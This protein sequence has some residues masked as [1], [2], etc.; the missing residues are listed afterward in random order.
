M[1]RVGRLLKAGALVA[2]RYGVFPRRITS[3]SGAVQYAFLYIPAA[4]VYRDALRVQSPLKLAV[5]GLP[6][7]I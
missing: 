6:G 4:V 2:F 3:A 1:R 7:L 5:G